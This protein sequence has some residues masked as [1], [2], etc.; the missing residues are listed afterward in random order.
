MTDFVVVVVVAD[1]V[2]FVGVVVVAVVAVIVDF[3][4]AAAAA[5]VVV[6]V[7]VVPSSLRRLAKRNVGR[8]EGTNRRMRPLT[9]IRSHFQP[10]GAKY[11]Y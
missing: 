7:V 9:Q 1:A 10:V 3:A 6:V 2:V 5:V 4:F 8:A 11:T